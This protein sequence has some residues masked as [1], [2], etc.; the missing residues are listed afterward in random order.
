MAQ[1]DPE[2]QATW[3]DDYHAGWSQGYRHGI[4]E[5]LTRA[6]HAVKEKI[7]TRDQHD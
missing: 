5:G 3:T 1:I 2:D 6:V 7:A 4:L